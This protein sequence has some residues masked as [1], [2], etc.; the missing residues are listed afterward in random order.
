MILW[1]KCRITVILDFSDHLLFWTDQNVVYIAPDHHQMGRWGEIHYTA[2]S[3]FTGILQ[4]CWIKQHCS[5]ANTDRQLYYWINGHCSLSSTDS[6]I[7]VHNITLTY[8]VLLKKQELFSFRYE[9]N[10]LTI[11][12]TK[13]QSLYSDT[14]WH[15][16]P[17]IRDYMTSLKP[18]SINWI[19]VNGFTL[20]MYCL[21]LAWLCRNM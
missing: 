21:M 14:F 5:L 9:L 6:C 10:V 20:G 15:N 13:S 16:H 7:T 11:C 1:V 18:L 8:T 2:S 3:I 19:T 12:E 17:I 4:Y